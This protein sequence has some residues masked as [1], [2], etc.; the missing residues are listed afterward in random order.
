[1][2]IS[3][4]A[5]LGK[6]A[7]EALWVRLWVTG[8]F[9]LRHAEVYCEHAFGSTIAA[10]TALCRVP[11]PY[12]ASFSGP[13][14]YRQVPQGARL[15]KG[16]DDSRA[17]ASIPGL[18]CG[19]RHLLQLPWQP[20]DSSSCLRSVSASAVAVCTGCETQ[21]SPKGFATPCIG[22]LFGCDTGRNTVQTVVLL[23]QT[24]IQ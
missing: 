10:D 12:P 3:S 8:S 20:D 15:A 4:A 23:E 19:C 16:E 6:T 24:L 22:P 9:T 18:H 21:G 13:M 2:V 7:P 5:S 1:M 14:G 17:G 11:L